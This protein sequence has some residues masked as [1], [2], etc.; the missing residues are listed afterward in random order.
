MQQGGLAGTG[1]PHDRGEG[2]PLDIEV[3]LVQGGHGA[4]PLPVGAPDGARGDRGGLIG[5]RGRMIGVELGAHHNP[6][7]TENGTPSILPVGRSEEHTSELQ[8]RGHLVCRLLLE[9]KK[10]IAAT[11]EESYRTT[12]PSN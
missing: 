5:G 3:H 6:S 1:G 12:N 8:S 4:G 11:K 9:K 7:G 2:S 10:S